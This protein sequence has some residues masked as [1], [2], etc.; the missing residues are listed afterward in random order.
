MAAA[1]TPPVRAVIRFCALSALVGLALLGCGSSA[2]PSRARR[3]RLEGTVVNVMKPQRQLVVNHKDIPGFMSAM[4][5]AYPVAGSDA[6]AL[7]SLHPG[8][9]ITADVVVGAG[10]IHLQHIVVVKKS[11]GTPAPPPNPPSLAKPG[12]PVPDFALVNQDG[13]RLRLRQFRGKAVLLTFIYT[14][15]PLPNYCPLMSRNFARIDAALAKNPAVYAQTRL[16]SIS[17]DPEHDTP[18]AL[19]RYGLSYL[20]K[21]GTPPFAHWQFTALRPSD[22]Q[23]ALKFFNVFSEPQNGGLISHTMCTAIIAPDGKLAKW[24]RGNDWK[25]ADVLA[26][27][28][29]LFPGQSASL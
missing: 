23:P 28:L 7:D 26:D 14:R 10:D 8:D 15:C 25:P 24:Y 12:D 4:T 3:Y 16:L 29:A 6:R 27:L 13:R 5:M 1:T 22:R 18:A 19:R 17:F 11:A 2:P 21:N 9:R 20:P